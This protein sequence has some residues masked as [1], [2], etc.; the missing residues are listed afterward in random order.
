[1]LALAEFLPARVATTPRGKGLFAEDHDLSL[2][3]LGFAGH[4]QARETVLGDQVDVLLTVGAALNE[5]TTFNWHRS[6]QPKRALLQVDIDTSRIGRNYPVTVPLVGDAQTILTELLYHGHRRIR[7]GAIPRSKW[8]AA[9]RLE[10]GHARYLDADLRQRESIPLSPQRWR[11]DLQQVLPED[12]IIFS[13]IGGHMLFNLH[14]LCIGRQQRFILN[15]GFGSMG[16][17]TA[18]PIGAA[19][20]ELGVPIVAIIGDG[21]FTMNGMELLTA[22]EY[23]VPV[24]WIVE[25][26]N[27]HGITW[28]GSK[29]V[30]DRRPL[31][32]VRYRQP[33]AP[34]AIARAMGM[35]S[36]IVE[37]PG[38][39]QEVFTTAS[40]RN[41]P[42]LIEVRID[43]TLPPPLGD[44]AKTIAGFTKA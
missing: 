13:D 16:H 4:Q 34:A 43:G 33:L 28:H 32:S 2:G 30:G 8:A 17:G 38:Q 37:A 23:D 11:C 31:E 5:T 20:A 41:E 26:N 18:A 40:R 44:R 10:R 9:P 27:M 12:A 36:W 35:Q 29:L 22:V 6:L 19:L 25:N 14:H 21:C 3:I 1:L 39:L 24:I 15:L 42:G 7:E